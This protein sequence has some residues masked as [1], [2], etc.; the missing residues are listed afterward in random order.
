VPNSTL[1]VLLYTTETNKA[2]QL[3]HVLSLL[4]VRVRFE[5][6]LSIVVN[7]LDEE[8]Y[9]IFI[10]QTEQIDTQ[11]SQVMQK[12]RD[13]LPLLFICLITEQSNIPK[14]LPVHY[15]LPKSTF[16][17]DSALKTHIENIFNLTTMYKRQ[18]ELSGM[19]LHDLR[20]PAQSI[21][22]Y[23]ELLEQK[24]F[25]DVNEGQRQILLS[26]VALG[27]SIIELMEELS[28]VYQFEKNQFELLKSKLDLKNL[29]EET[30]RALWVQAD[31]KNI[32]FT[33]KIAT[34]LPVIVADNL[35]M[36]RLLNNLIYNAIKFSPENGTVRIEVQPFENNSVQFK[37]VDSGP[38]LPEDQ[39]DQV[40][41]KFFRIIDYKHKQKGQGLGLYICK[42][43]AEAHGGTI[44]AEN[45]IE[46]GMTFTFTIPVS[47]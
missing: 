40:F 18:A 44:K 43:I 27:D 31:R 4:P 19:L 29:M 20:S 35:A 28:Q 36:Q 23:I 1:D 2:D 46:S 37:I 6:Q 26:A 8:S 13:K 22:G 9:D 41:D 39:V 42:L 33:S 12:L 5:E 11:L 14:T 38:G 3:Q 30:L 25:G 34:E 16:E 17:N 45:N 10:C 24:V 21:I 15:I 32:K 47:N 7:Q